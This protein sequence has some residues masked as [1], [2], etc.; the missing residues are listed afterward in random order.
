MGECLPYKEKV[1][2]SSPI[3]RI[4]GLQQIIRLARLVHLVEHFHFKKKVAGSNPVFCKQTLPLDM[5]GW[6]SSVEG[7]AL[8]RRRPR[9]GSKGSNPLPHA[10]R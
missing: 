1:I 8:L 6:P 9:L 10:N 3:S 5:C 4:R 7:S 2:G